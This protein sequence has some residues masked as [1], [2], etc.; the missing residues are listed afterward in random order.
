[1]NQSRTSVALSRK[2]FDMKITVLTSAYNQE[3]FIEDCIDC[4]RA[5]KGN[6]ELEHLIIDDVSADHTP[7]LISS[8]AQRFSHI[9][10]ILRTVNRNDLNYAWQYLMDSDYVA[11]LDG[12]DYWIDSHKLQKQV[13]YMEARPDVLLTGTNFYNY[14]YSDGM[15]YMRYYWE[16]SELI[17]F[18]SLVLD[19]EIAASTMMIKKALIHRL[20]RANIKTPLFDRFMATYASMHGKVARLSYYTTIK[21]M[22]PNN[23]YGNKSREQKNELIEIFFTKLHESANTEYHRSIIQAAKEV[24]NSILIEGQPEP[25]P[26]SNQDRMEFIDEPKMIIQKLH[27]EIKLK[28][29][30]KSIKL[31][32]KIEHLG[33]THPHLSILSYRLSHII[34]DRRFFI[35]RYIKHGHLFLEHPQVPKITVN[36]LI[37]F[38]YFK[39][40]LDYL[41]RLSNDKQ[42]LLSEEIFLLVYYLQQNKVLLLNRQK[43]KNLR[44]HLSRLHR[45][46]LNLNRSINQQNIPK[47]HQILKR[48]NQGGTKTGEQKTILKELNNKLQKASS[49]NNN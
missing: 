29:R 26:L 35:T 7:D 3:D 12:D 36:A 11:I 18:K 45:Q 43:L 2:T 30:A 34:K 5:Q 23:V 6:F 40:A 44:K 38:R 39:E 28:N 27:A 37:N 33:M 24:K 8:A 13:D 41:N 21:G 32:D 14:H 15:L 47:S 49:K 19:N 31:I 25:N 9:R 1:M 20:N 42:S 4:V 16:P 22:H 17:S 10:P 46:L 48:I